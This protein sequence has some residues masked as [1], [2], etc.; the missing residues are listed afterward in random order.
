M[1]K[2]QKLGINLSYEA[3]VVNVVGKEEISIKN[4]IP[5]EHQLRDL[6]PLSDCIG[7]M[8]HAPARIRSRHC[9]QTTPTCVLSTVGFVAKGQKLEW[10]LGHRSYVHDT[11]LSC[12]AY[13]LFVGAGVLCLLTVVFHWAF[14]SSGRL[15]QVLPWNNSVDFR[16]YVINV[17]RPLYP[18]QKHLRAVRISRF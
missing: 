12:I 8:F 1:I 3:A 2:H 7:M 11:V 6:L 15:H 5:M 10:N 13:T 17:A 9:H 4:R 14:H 16:D 18:Y